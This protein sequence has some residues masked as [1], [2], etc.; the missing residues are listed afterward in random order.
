[1]L[2]RGDGDGQKDKRGNLQ[3]AVEMVGSKMNEDSMS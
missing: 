2:V 3:Y 1:M